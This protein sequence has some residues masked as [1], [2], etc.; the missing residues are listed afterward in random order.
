M[1]RTPQGSRLSPHMPDI[2][3]RA[4]KWGPH[5]R[6]S[7]QGRVGALG[8]HM[9]EECGRE[10]FWPAEGQGLLVRLCPPPTWAYQVPVSDSPP[11]PPLPP[12]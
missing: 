10:G 1:C 5:M 2:P 8:P 6:G 3:Q 7:V 9:A 11:D 12:G 4:E